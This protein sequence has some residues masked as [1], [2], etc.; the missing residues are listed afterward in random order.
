MM[1]PPIAHLEDC[2]MVHYTLQISEYLLMLES[3][4]FR[5]G[6]GRIIHFPP[7][8]PIAPPGALPPPP[9]IYPVA[10]WKKDVISMLQQLPHG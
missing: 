2:S 8:L 5:A 7:V 4:G 10:Y 9:V 3:M 6:T 1:K